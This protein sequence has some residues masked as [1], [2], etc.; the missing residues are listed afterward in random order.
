MSYGCSSDIGFAHTQ[1]YLALKLDNMDK[2]KSV[3]HQRRCRRV[4]PSGKPTLKY[5]EKED[6]DGLN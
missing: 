6:K 3:K 4:M 2:R 1:V 5:G